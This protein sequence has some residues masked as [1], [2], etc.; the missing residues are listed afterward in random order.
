MLG[1]WIL[2]AFILGLGFGFALGIKKEKEFDVEEYIDEDYEN[3][4]GV[5]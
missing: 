3:W 1:V 4:K 5:R 2:I